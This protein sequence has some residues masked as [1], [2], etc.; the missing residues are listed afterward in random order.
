MNTSAQEQDV[1]LFGTCPSCKRG[2]TQLRPRGRGRRPIY[3]PDCRAVRRVRRRGGA[4]TQSGTQPGQATAHTKRFSDDTL[5]AILAS[6]ADAHAGALSGAAYETWRQGRTLPSGLP[7]PTRQTYAIRFGSWIKAC[8]ALGYGD[9][10]PAAR[11]KYK[12][13]WELSDCVEAV[14]RFIAEGHSPTAANYEAWARVR[15]D[16]PSLALPRQRGV[17]WSDLVARAREQA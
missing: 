14:A 10:A 8:Q 12:R 2:W 11:R 17:K 16:V 6:F 13:R 3:C 9:R 4:G 1:I 5:G 15:E 7:Y